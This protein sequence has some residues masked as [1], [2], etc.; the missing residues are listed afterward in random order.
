VGIHAMTHEELIGRWSHKY[1]DEFICDLERLKTQPY[2][3]LQKV[4]SK[5]KMT[6]QNV[7]Q[8]FY[9]LF[10]R[11]IDI[12][13][14]KTKKAREE[15]SRV[16]CYLVDR[17][18]E[19]DSNSQTYP[20]IFA[21]SK[22]LERC[23][24]KGFLVEIKRICG[25]YNFFVINGFKI[26]IHAT[27]RPPWGSTRIKYYRFMMG[28]RK[29]FYIIDNLDFLAF[30]ILPRDEFFIIPIDQL[31]KNL[32]SYYICSPLSPMSDM[33][34]ERRKQYCENWSQLCGG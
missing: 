3:T 5:Y 7:N 14:A 18:Q 12:K 30:Y 22:F 16:G 27:N 9:R 32:R 33:H 20:H 29:G 23:K 13:R 8:K 4:A 19:C 6:R 28:G 24:V 26:K 10:G 21:E 34:K 25:G 17:L 15:S 11:Y 31:C 1:G 2:L